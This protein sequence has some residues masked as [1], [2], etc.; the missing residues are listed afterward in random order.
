[1]ILLYIAVGAIPRKNILYEFLVQ[2]SR[3][4]DIFAIYLPALNRSMKLDKKYRHLPI[5]YVLPK[6][7][8]FLQLYSLVVISSRLIDKHSKCGEKLLEVIEFIRYLSSTS[9]IFLHA[10]QSQIHSCFIVHI[11]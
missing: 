9:P 8:A 5:V 4:C 7:E 6:P 2:L 1:M 3:I 11:I 10:S